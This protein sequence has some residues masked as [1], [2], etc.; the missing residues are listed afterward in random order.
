MRPVTETI[1]RIY[2]KGD[3]HLHVWPGHDSSVQIHTGI[4]VRLDAEGVA[5]LKVALDD[6]LVFSELR[7]KEGRQK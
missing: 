4:C 5:A 6:A 2:G 1:T 3:T 7:S